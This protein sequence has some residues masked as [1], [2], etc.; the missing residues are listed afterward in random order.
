MLGIHVRSEVGIL[1]IEL[2][3]V[4]AVSVV[5]QHF[6]VLV[7]RDVLLLAER[8]LV[9]PPTRD[10]ADLEPVA[11]REG[12]VELLRLHLLPKLGRDLG[13]TLIVEVLSF[14]TEAVRAVP[15]GRTVSVRI[16]VLP[17]RGLDDLHMATAVDPDV[18]F[19]VEFERGITGTGEEQVLDIYVRSQLGILKVKLDRVSAV[20]VVD[21]HVGQV[22]RRDVLLL[23][24][25]P[26]EVPPAGDDT[27]LEPV[28]VR[29]GDVE[30]LRLHLLP[31]LGRNL[32]DAFLA[33]RVRVLAFEAEAVHT[34]PVGITEAGRIRILPDGDLVLLPVSAFGTRF[35]RELRQQE[36]LAVEGTK[37][38]H[39]IAVEDFLGDGYHESV[40]ALSVEVL[41]REN[42]RIAICVRQLDLADELQ[43]R[44]VDLDLLTT[45]DG[46]CLDRKAGDAGRTEG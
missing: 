18:F 4:R 3:G 19:E 37:F 5:D 39:I 26:L 31:G 13:D 8:P 32:S 24:L 6:R 28:V 12:D 36:F 9:V 10:D 7:R 44:T 27:H 43:V 40:L 1:E 16:V 14:L 34:V 38:S 22:G 20:A 25:R 41:V 45:L 17:E 42:H 30:L 15:V 29:E 2:D 11:V 46:P 33:G 21:E 23:A 35:V